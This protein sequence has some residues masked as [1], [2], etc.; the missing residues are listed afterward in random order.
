MSKSDSL[1]QLGQ[2]A[3]VGMAVRFPGAKNITEFWQNL[4][5]GV[6]SVTFFSDEEM[7]AAGVPAALINHPKYVKANGVLDDIEMFDAAFFNINRKEAQ[8]ID[9][10]HRFFLE[11]AWEA[12]EDA[13]YDSARYQGRIGM[14]ASESMNSYFLLNLYSNQELIQSLGTVQTVLGNDRDFLA[15]R[16]SFNFDLKGPSIVVQSACSSSLVAVHLACQSL[17][18]GECDMALAGGVSISLPQKAGYMFQEGGIY[19][20]DGH[21]RAFD[22]RAGGTVGGNGVGVVVLKRLDDALADGDMIHAVIKGSAINNDGSLKIG[23]TA[24]SVEGQ[25]RVIAEAL[26]VARVDPAT[27]GYVEAHGT[28]TPLGD[29]VEIEALTQAFRHSTNRKTFCAIGS[30]KTNLGHLD[31][32]AGVAGLIKA[33]LALRHKELPPSLHFDQPNPKIDFANSSFYVNA[34]LNDWQAGSEPRRAGVSSFG[35][36][37]TNAH[38]VLEEAPRRKTSAGWPYHLLVLSAKTGPALEGATANLLC[39]LKQHPDSYLADVAYTLQVGRRNFNHA[40]MLVCRTTEDGITALETKRFATR[41]RESQAPGVVFMFS[42]Q[43]TQYVNM[44]RELYDLEPHYRQEVDHCAKL[45]TPHLGIDIR[46]VIYPSAVKAEADL[47]LI[48]TSLTQPAL[49]VTEYALAKLLMSWGVRP[50]AMIGHSLGEYVAACIAEVFSLEDALALV[51]VRGRMIQALPAGAMLSVQLSETEIHPLLSDKLS[52]AAV[53]GSSL[54][55]VSGPTTAI[56]AL[57]E[58]LDESG[59]ASSKLRT[60][61]AFHSAMMNE[62]MDPFARKAQSI[63]L[64][65]PHIPY[66]SNLTGKWITAAEATDATYWSR[67]LRYAVRFA[68]GLALL[69]KN[70]RRV[71]LEVGPGHTLS[72]L[73]RR[74]PDK[75]TQET[76]SSLRASPEQK[77][78]EEYL[79]NAIGRLW[80][81]GI[82]IDWP[83]MQMNEQGRLRISLPTYPFQHQP[84]WIEPVS[85]KKSRDT[86]PNE[87]EDELSRSAVTAAPMDD[88]SPLARP[89]NAAGRAKEA[90]AQMSQVPMIGPKTDFTGKQRIW[91]TLKSVITEL[92]GAD[93]A[94]INPAATFFELGVDSLLL[95]QAAQAIEKRF[96]IELSFRQLLEDYPTLDALANY[97]EQHADAAEPQTA[98]PASP[99]LPATH[100]PAAPGRQLA[101]NLSQH[102]D[103]GASQGAG[104]KFVSISDLERMM[105]EM[106]NVVTQQ[107]DSLR[108]GGAK[109]E[110]LTTD[111]KAGALSSTAAS[112]G[113]Q[114]VRN[115]ARMDAIAPLPETSTQASGTTREDPQ[116]TD[117]KAPT[118]K[119]VPEPFVPFHTIKLGPPEGL[120]PLQQNRLSE[121]IERYT[122]R[123]RKSKDLIQSSRVYHADARLSLNYRQQWKNLVY[124]IVG[125]RSR[126]SR[127]WDADDNEYLDLTMGFGV[128]LFGHSP[129]FLVQA[130]E[131][132]I[133]QGFQLGPQSAVAGEVAQLLCELTGMQRAAFCNSGT[134]AIMAA[135]RL[136]RTATGRNKIALFTG[137]YHGSFDGILARAIRENGQ[138]RAVPL[139]PGVPPSLID[140]VIVLD[141]DR[142]ESLEVVR[143]HEHELAAVLVEPVQ[144][145]R[146]DLQPAGFLRALRE[147]TKETGTILIFDEVI[148]GFR[149]HPGGAQAWFDI[150]ADLAVYGK[151]MGGGMPIGAL[152]G[153][154]AIMDAIDGGMWN[155]ADDSYPKAQQTYFAGTFFKNPLAMAAARAVL[156]HLK[157]SGPILQQQLNERTAE[158]AARLNNLFQQQ[159]LALNV[160][161]CASLFRFNFPRDLKFADLF[162]YHL[163]DKGIYIWEGRNCFLST[164]HTNADLDFLVRAVEQTVAEMRAGEFLPS[165]ADHASPDVSAKQQPIETAPA[166]APL[167]AIAG[168]SARRLSGQGGKESAISAKLFPLTEGQQQVWLASQLGAAASVAYNESINLH[169]RGKC[170][171]AALRRAIE[172]L[173]ERHE[174]LRTTF[175]PLGDYQQIKP[176]TKVLVP[177]LDFSHLDKTQR[178]AQVTGWLAK[179]VQEPFDLAHGPL[180][181]AHIA[182]LED[183]YHLLVLT[184][185]HLVMDGWSAGVLLRELREIYS[186]ECQALECHLPLPESYSEF[187]RRLMTGEQSN[188]MVQAE[189]FWLKQFADGIPVLNL[190]LDHARPPVQTFNGDRQRAILNG[191]ISQELKKLSA[192]QGCT[193]FVTLLVAFSVVLRQLSGQDDF[194]VGIHSAGQLTSNV[195][196]L[197]G[198]CINLLPFRTRIDGALSFTEYLAQVR[199]E[200]LDVYSHQNYPLGK[201]IKKLNPPRDP[202]RSPLIAVTFNVDRAGQPAKFYGLEVDVV[203]N[204]NGHSKFDLSVNLVEETDHLEME[205]DYNT[206]LFEAETVRRWMTSFEIT[207]RALL[208]NPAIKLKELK[209]IIEEGVRQQQRLKEQEFKESRRQKLKNLKRRA[210]VQGNEITTER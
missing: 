200:L 27:I 162:F 108:R 70:S 133:D 86:A 201:L 191:G 161:H 68:E 175:S 23:Y 174:S 52:V 77:S 156:R 185:H 106:L 163:I 73:A 72:A 51:A 64:K 5:A 54:C 195:K 138:L 4:R 48:K 116:A 113:E 166:V 91:S 19:S 22:A 132:Q 56:A 189:M 165:A 192:Q 45:L 95:I 170:N 203:V 187:A 13:A 143:A 194:I 39:Y 186:A 120:T 169:M 67:H 127:L 57:Q 36:G 35:I 12:L 93:L 144:S 97:L 6:E 188:E 139:S 62:I 85:N 154:S 58:K 199:H 110:S 50:E 88:T 105:T 117:E 118:L 47:E 124:P 84:Y 103:N 122:K 71:L 63:S 146:P 80:L 190:P 43:G 11:C 134:E 3:V 147:L 140:D 155:F 8:I 42:G 172:K 123:T 61:H 179:E 66:I 1:A 74:H 69:L 78:D 100:E 55:T 149:L 158:L 136:A 30:V 207:L 59:I 26:A 17:S 119:I 65:P 2:I 38:V 164:A 34:S 135:L 90:E 31:A 130:L 60:S 152:A 18:C 81:E 101:A 83:K 96:G 33:V 112:A 210:A 24:P 159:S 92:T 79:L 76:I 29:P 20:P 145:R 128:S 121:F 142:P 75:S 168:G 129:P 114:S 14:F 89:G 131:Q 206:D 87:T 102:H 9:P 193:T 204:H 208:S 151:I 104:E 115:Q 183:E 196:D 7:E 37:G 82:E 99:E 137:S 148:T 209:E 125:A 171:V 40:R 94:E 25:A 21:C 182:R 111:L 41:V 177:L 109:A 53:N 46:E 150:R 181:R 157:N 16:A 205:C 44:G 167:S 141:Y 15:T 173:V 198:Y 176:D 160:V 32:A 28:G 49:F 10:Q 184:I 126:G 98:Q 180:L 107:I 197:I 178:Q 153:K 202:S